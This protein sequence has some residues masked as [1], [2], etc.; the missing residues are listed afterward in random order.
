MEERILI[1]FS[2]SLLGGGIGAWVFL[3]LMH[4]WIGGRPQAE[5]TNSLRDVP[6]WIVGVVERFFFTFLIYF[7]FSGVP[8]AM[9]IWLT[10]KM[11]TDW[12]SPCKSNSES[13]NKRYSLTALLAGLVS[14]GFA[15][16]GGLI[17]S[18]T[19]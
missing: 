3:K 5:K 17:A 13:Y 7:E 6:S 2:V 1:G 15:A 10:L 12:N 18:G 19:L 11:V 4:L 14:L 16:Y 9:L 8:A